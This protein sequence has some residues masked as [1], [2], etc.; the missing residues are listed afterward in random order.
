MD[1]SLIL[2]IANRN[3]GKPKKYAN[4]VEF[5]SPSQNFKFTFGIIDYLQ[6]YNL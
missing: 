3:E 1:Y 6:Q 5:S 2:I 4:Q